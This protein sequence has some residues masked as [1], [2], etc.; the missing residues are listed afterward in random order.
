MIAFSYGI[1]VAISFVTLI[2]VI[3]SWI[4]MKFDQRSTVVFDMDGVRSSEE[5]KIIHEYYLPTRAAVLILLTMAA[6]IQAFW[7]WLALFVF[8][9]SV[10]W[11]CFDIFCAV[12]WL[13]K[14]WY[15]AGDPPP[16]GWDPILFFFLKGAILAAS[17]W[18]YIRL[19]T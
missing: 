18:I 8:T 9:L 15:Y 7:P 19:S 4:E 10:F 13:G 17:L 3:Y 2:G 6:D 16:F 11:I 12:V 1:M 14:P 5:M